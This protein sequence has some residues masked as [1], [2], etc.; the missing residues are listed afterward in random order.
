MA[1]VETT[2][3]SFAARHDEDQAAEA[4]R[5]LDRLEV[6]RTRLAE[7][8]PAV[9]EEVAVVIHPRPFM[10]ALAHPWLPLA[11]VAAA[12]AA[13]RYMAGWFTA[14]EIHVLSPAAL[15]TRASRVPGS[16]EALE[17]SPE[18]EYA[19]L[20][21]GTSNKLLPPPFSPASFAR[22]LRWAWLAEGAA[23]WLSGQTPHLR[24]A[25]SRRLREGARP[26]FPPATKD[27]FL[28]GG[29]I[30]DLLEEGAGREA[31]IALALRLEP[32]GPNSAIER[33]FM[34]SASE[35]ERDWRAHLDGLATA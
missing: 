14:R 10:L 5:L 15:R 13:R 8:L 18:H 25:I 21:L 6:F 4:S 30:F 9:P 24:P 7:D 19:H 28:L 16:H 3:A 27:S 2:S 31:C 33:A 32:D 22:Y 11:R 12:P 17:L 1:W 34:R 26:E 20:A 23:S 29:T 35:V